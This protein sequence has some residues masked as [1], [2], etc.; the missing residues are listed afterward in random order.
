M[1]TELN[2][3][4]KGTRLVFLPSDGRKE[5]REERK[6]TFFFFSSDT[7]D[8]FAGG[9]SL[10]NRCWTWCVVPEAATAREGMQIIPKTEKR[11][12]DRYREAHTQKEND[13][14]RETERTREKERKE[15]KE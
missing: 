10:V 11:C 6:E 13:R 4:T 7:K 2:G 9:E 3:V 1:S 5:R 8:Y 15:S 12:S 14:E